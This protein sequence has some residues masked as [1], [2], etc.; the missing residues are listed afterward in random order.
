MLLPVAAAA[1][2]PA[3][4][5]DR[6]TQMNARNFEARLL[7]GH[8]EDAVEVPFDPTELGLARVSLRPGR[9]GYRV[10]ATLNGVAFDSAIVARS[11]RFW[12]LV[13]ASVAGGIGI[14]VGDPVRVR[15]HA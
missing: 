14:A 13:P 11:G 3:Q 2:P 6:R 9:R 15:L 1:A 5:H 4:P 7:A 12:L 10:A 8:K